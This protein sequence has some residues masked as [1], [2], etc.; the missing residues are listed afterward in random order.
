M[1]VAFVQHAQH[2]VDRH[3]RGQNQQRLVRERGLKG[4]R[5]FPGSWP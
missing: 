2:D 3:Q 1:D 5:P 4:L